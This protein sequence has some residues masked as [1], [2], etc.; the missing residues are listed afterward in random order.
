LRDRTFTLAEST[1]ATGPGVAII[2]QRLA[3]NLFGEADAFGQRVFFGEDAAAR[4]DPSQA[5]EIVGI[6]RRPRDEVFADEAPPRFYRP[7]G[8]APASN[9]YLHLGTTEP[10]RRVDTVRRE[11]RNIEGVAPVLFIRP[12]ATFVD[13][14]INGLL[15][16]LAALIFGLFGG[17]ALLLVVVDVK[18]VKSHAAAR[19]TREIGIRMALGARPAEIMALIPCQGAQQTL[20]GLLVGIA[21]SLGASKVLASMIHQADAASALPLSGSAIILV[22]A[23][24][25]ACWL[26]ARRASRVTPPPRCAACDPS[27]ATIFSRIFSLRVQNCGSPPATP[28][29]R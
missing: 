1:Q 24:L 9:I 25:F 2:D 20:V 7:L 19:R 18:G 4:G 27:P 6:V 14:N 26:P 13:Q 12:L 8:Q 16:E 3:K 28:C 5:L 21:L 17:I 15:I 29:R 23:V 11:L 22:F 10:L